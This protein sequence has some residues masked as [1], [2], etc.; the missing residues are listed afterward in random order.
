MYT[1]DLVTLINTVV[2]ARRWTERVNEPRN[3]SHNWSRDSV[4]RAD[5]MIRE[6]SLSGVQMQ[7]SEAHNS[8]PQ[9]HQT[10]MQNLKLPHFQE[11]VS[12]T[13]ARQRFRDTTLGAQFIKSCH[14]GCQG[15]MKRL[16]QDLVFNAESLDCGTLGG[17][18]QLGGVGYWGVPSPLSAL[19]CTGTAKPLPHE[20]K[21]TFLPLIKPFLSD[22]CHWKTLDSLKLKWLVIHIVWRTKGQATVGAV[23]C[24]SHTWRRTVSRSYR[25]KSAMKK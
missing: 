1:I 13:E 11:N 20:P 12:W 21:L 5:A 7:T 22:I 17:W 19:L 8:Q 9:I 16:S 24:T 6:R 10:W 4:Q 14:A 18:V 2:L 25:N 23:T 15:Q 3:N